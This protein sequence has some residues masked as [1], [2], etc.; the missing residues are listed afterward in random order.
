[1]DKIVEKSNI[2]TKRDQIIPM[3]VEGIQINN[4]PTQISCLQQL[5]DLSERSMFDSRWINKQI[6]PKI[7][8]ILNDKTPATQQV[9]SLRVNALLSLSKIFKIF[10]ADIIRTTIL[11]SVFEV[12]EVSHEPPILVSVL[13]VC[14]AIANHSKDSTMIAND[15]LPKLIPL[16]MDNSLNHRQ[17]LLFTKIIHSMLDIIEKFRNDNFTQAEQNMENKDNEH[18][19]NQE[20]KPNVE[21]DQNNSKTDNVT[22]PSSVEVKSVNNNTTQ[23]DEN[24][25]KTDISNDLITI[26][27]NVI[28]VTDANNET[29]EKNDINEN[30]EKQ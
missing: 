28:D 14:D 16:S 7:R 17:Y 13:G 30:N 27:T 19:D 26:E 18:K 20:I 22:T 3:M 1:L 4:I 9:T 6:L 23:N 10:E 2:E 24:K 29:R 11:T 5:S 8:S 15:M 21:N 25:E 12:L